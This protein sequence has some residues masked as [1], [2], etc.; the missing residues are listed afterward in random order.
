MARASTTLEEI[1]FIGQ[2]LALQ[3]PDA[4]FDKRRWDIAFQIAADEFV[5]KTRCIK[6]SDVSLSMTVD[7]AFLDYNSITD[8]HPSRVYEVELLYPGGSAWADSTT[9]AINTL[10]TQSNKFYVCQAVHTGPGD[11]TTSPATDTTNWSVVYTDVV[12]E[13]VRR[14]YDWVR[15]NLSARSNQTYNP[16]QPFNVFN[17]TSGE[18]YV[19]FQESGTDA[20]FSFIPD[21]AW[22]VRFIYWSPV[23][24]WTAGSMGVYDDSTEYNPGD[25]VSRSALSHLALVTTTGNDP[26]HADWDTFGGTSTYPVVAP[27]TAT[28]NI[29]DDMIKGVAMWGATAYYDFA[30]SGKRHQ[31]TGEF[32][33]HI[34]DCLGQVGDQRTSTVKEEMFD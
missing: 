7:S 2:R 13:A 29:P 3:L 11:A 15:D 30:T 6:T 22:R 18:Y 5:R 4:G 12:A 8:M 9:Y 27:A 32:Q 25:V 10:V 19:G 17:T 21:T 31:A 20:V 23:T 28:I 1:R 26:P 34:L 24:S 16:G 33:R 14:E